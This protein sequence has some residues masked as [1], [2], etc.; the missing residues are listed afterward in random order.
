MECALYRC[1]D[2]AQRLNGDRK[3]HVAHREKNRHAGK[4]DENAAAD[5]E[6]R[7]AGEG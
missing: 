6:C 3:K 7:S 2:E 1:P 5:P 4:V